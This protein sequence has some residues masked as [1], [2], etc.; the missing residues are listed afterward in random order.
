[1]VRFSVKLSGSAKFSTWKM[2]DEFRSWTR[3]ELAQHCKS[4]FDAAN[5]RIRRLEQ[6]QLLS[7]A[8]HA[9]NSSGGEFHARGLNLKQLQHEYARCIN[10][11][12]MSTSSPSTAK[13]YQRMIE[14]KIGMPLSRDQHSLLFKA[15]RAIE[16]ASPAG[17]QTYGSNR[18]IQYLA[19]EITAEDSNIMEGVGSQDWERMIN[20]TIDELIREYE[21][22]MD[23][24]NNS[25][26]DSF[27]F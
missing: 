19:N 13:A 20:D 8:L 25:F 14:D 27:S 7:P 6:Q 24:F 16:K 3:K 15:F 17:V 4:C 21:K 11:L 5:K 12:N 2:A 1:M 9:V 22:V 23:D 18:L 26:K 10:F